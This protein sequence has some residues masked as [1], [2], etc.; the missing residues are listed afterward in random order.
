[1]SFTPQRLYVPSVL[2]VM[3]VGNA[4][5]HDASTCARYA[6]E[7]NYASRHLGNDLPIAGDASFAHGERP[8]AIDNC[9]RITRAGL[10]VTIQ[11]WA[12]QGAS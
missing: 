12:D 3:P 6:Y 4:I 2:M 1:M 5:E 7:R 10:Q 9:W 8:P 11:L